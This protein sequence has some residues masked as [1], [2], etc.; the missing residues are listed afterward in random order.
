MV[1]KQTQTA[2]V[3]SQLKKNGK[4]SRNQALKRY[5]SRLGALI[6]D[7]RHDFNMDIRGGYVSKNGGRDFVYFLNHGQ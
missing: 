2:W 3:Y 1:K 6:Y 4:V 7:L 5:I